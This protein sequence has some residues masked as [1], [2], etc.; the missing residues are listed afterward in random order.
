[1][2][3]KSNLAFGR[4][5]VLGASVL[6]ASAGVAY[7]ADQNT[8]PVQVVKAQLALEVQGEA[9]AQD[10]VNQAAAELARQG[11]RVLEA[12]RTLLGRLK[13]TAE[14]ATA[15]REVVISSSTGAVMRDAIVKVFADGDGGAN[16]K[17]SAGAN[18]Q[19]S[20]QAGASGSG[21]ASSLGNVA[22]SLGGGVS[23]GAEG[24]ASSS[25]SADAAGQSG[26]SAGASAGGSVGG[27]LGL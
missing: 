1:M 13:L 21:A 24:R 25:G 4:S 20:V 11:Y 14:S 3:T 15:R 19:T 2:N 12:K 22:S 26:G 18:S 6:L 9:D 7:G 8:G 10:L 17:A 16:A 5:L 27:G 23:I